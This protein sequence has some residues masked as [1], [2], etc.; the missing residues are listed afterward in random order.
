MSVD[1]AFK[2]YETSD[3]VV[4]QIWGKRGPNM[5]LVHQVRKHLNFQ[6]TM[7]TI[8]QLKA[9]YLVKEIL[10]EDKANGSAIIQVLRRKI[11]GIIPVEPRGSK[12]SRVNAISFAIESGNVF[13]PSNKK[14]TKEFIEE[15]SQFPNGKHDDMVDAMSQA[16]S[17]LIWRQGKRAYRKR[18]GPWWAREQK[19][20]GMTK[21]KKINVI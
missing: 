1:A 14:Y 11:E 17:R 5:Y 4:I 7:D 15:C 8:V 10:I 21:G 12:E 6:A 3:Y 2:D 9:L 18:Q 19:Q 20:A 13:V 16:L